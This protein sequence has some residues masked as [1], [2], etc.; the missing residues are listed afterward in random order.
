MQTK[1]LPIL[2]AVAV[3]A[4]TGLAQAGGDAAAGAAKAK[5]CVACHGA[6]GEGKGKTPAIAGLPED[7]L[8]K[9][10]HDYKSGARKNL[11]MKMITKKLSDQDMADLAAYY[12]SLK[13]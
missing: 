1:W 11:M 13:N 10:L 5:R 8:V 4:T 7:V 12:H 3:F 2:A 6:K 9:A